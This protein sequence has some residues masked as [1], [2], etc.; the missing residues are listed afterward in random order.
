LKGHG[1]LENLMITGKKN[2][3]TSLK[4]KMGFDY[5]P[6]KN[7]ILSSYTKQPNNVFIAIHLNVSFIWLKF[8]LNAGKYSVH[9]A[10]GYVK[11]NIYIYICM[12]PGSPC[13]RM[14]GVYNHLL[15]AQ[16]L[17]WITILRR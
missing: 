10:S 3:K 13:Q 8:M 4:K 14:I 6:F 1:N 5:Y 9:G 12:D 7:G 16:C 11:S 17:G 15:N 2:M